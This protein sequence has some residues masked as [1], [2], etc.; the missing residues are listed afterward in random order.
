MQQSNHISF[1]DCE[2]FVDEMEYVNLLRGIVA[3]TCRSGRFIEMY[4]LASEPELQETIWQIAALPKHRMNMVKE[5]V[6][7]LSKDDATPD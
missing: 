4:F 1:S 5:L 7:M 3:D 2:E 6:A